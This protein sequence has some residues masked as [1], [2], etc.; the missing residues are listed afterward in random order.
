MQTFILSVGLALAVVVPGPA[1]ES[2]LLAQGPKN[3]TKVQQPES[4]RKKIDDRQRI[5]GDWRFAKMQANGVDIPFQAFQVTFSGG[6]EC[7]MSMI[8]EFAAAS[9]AAE[10]R[11]S[12]SFRYKLVWPGEIETPAPLLGGMKGRG[13]TTRKRRR[14]S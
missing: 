2:R 1:T 11:L 5:V 8:E 4:A 9:P 6:G 7:I 14:R 10:Q 12:F 13:K 3:L